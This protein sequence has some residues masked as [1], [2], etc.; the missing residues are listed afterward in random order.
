MAN[1]LSS[2]VSTKVAKVILEGF[3]A[4]RVLSKTINTTI[5][6]GQIQP[7][8]GSTVYVKRPTQYSGIETS[9]GDISASTLNDI[10]VGRAA[11]TVQNYITVPVNYINLEEIT[12]LD[13]LQELLAP[14]AAELATKLELNLGQRMIEQSALTYGTP[15]TAVD[16]WSDVAGANALLGSIGVP[17][18]D[19]YYI[20][21]DFTQVN[22]ASAQGALKFDPAV[23]TAWEQARI[24][25]PFA[26]MTSMASNA[27]KQ[28]TSGAAVDRAGTLAATPNATWATHKDT[29]IQ[30]LSLT[31]LTA[32]TA[33]AVRAGDVLEFT[34]TGASARSFV[35]VATRQ[36]VLGADGTPVK[37]RCTVV[38]GGNTDG[39]GAV[40]VTVTNAAI[41]G[42][43]GGQDQQYTNISAPLTSGDVFNILGST[44]TVYQ[45]SMFYHKNA[46]A[47][48]TIKLPKLFATD[49]IATTKDGLSFRVTRYSDGDR[50]KQKWRIDLLPVFATLNPLFAG[51]GFGV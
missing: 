50:N 14:A 3:E 4:S 46:F 32:S 21:N 39:A 28:Y 27:L 12:Q 42:A 35:N 15:G 31:G 13:Q 19:R 17:V 1:N 36:T 30:T 18:G 38:T 43:A 7:D 34:G 41:Y 2:N 47:I 24:S 8:T 16:A 10:A 25:T 33:N 29:M 40:T 26:G 49:T 51:K 9:D 48:A 22:L 45:P 6:D 23:K 11:A 44:S 5:V 37:W 20:M